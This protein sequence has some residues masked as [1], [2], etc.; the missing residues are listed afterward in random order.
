MLRWTTIPCSALAI[1]L[2]VS[3]CYEASASIQ[4]GPVTNVNDSEL[5]VAEYDAEPSGRGSTSAE[6]S[7]NESDCSHVAEKILLL[8]NASNKSPS[9]SSGPSSSTPSTSGSGGGAL[10]AAEGFQLPDINGRVER[11]EP[12]NS[13]LY[14]AEFIFRLMRPPR[15][16]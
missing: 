15:Y 9:P 11:I 16:S 7:E 8:W 12:E 3:L 5:V 2:S 13:I 14:L 6:T 1:A 10:L 4:L